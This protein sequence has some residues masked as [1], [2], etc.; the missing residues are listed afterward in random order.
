MKRYVTSL[1]DLDDRPRVS[2]DER[3]A[4]DALDRAFG[5]ASR[6]GEARLSCGCLRDLKG[7]IA[8]L[9]R[10]LATARAATTLATTELE[11]SR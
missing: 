4:L 1:H 3:I 2:L 7:Y 5:V 6:F 9:E 10:E 8:R 11:R